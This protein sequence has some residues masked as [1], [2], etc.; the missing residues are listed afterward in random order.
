[1]HKPIKEGIVADKGVDKKLR[2]L[3]ARIVENCSPKR[4][5]LFGSYARGDYHEGSDVDLAIVGDF[6]E[7][8]IDRIG[9][10]LDL[11]DTSLEIE[12][13]AYTEDEFSRMEKRGN[14]F[15]TNVKKGKLVYSS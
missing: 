2:R 6:R 1:M 10:I 3:L 5:Y 8:F 9:R 12:P 13:M 4:I 15:I 11:N 14:A 7:R